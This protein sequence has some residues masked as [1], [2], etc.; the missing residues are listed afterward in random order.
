M[1]SDLEKKMFSF[2]AKITELEVRNVEL[3]E[4][5]TKLEKKQLENVIIKNLLHA[6]CVSTFGQVFQKT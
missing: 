1:E 6:S 2:M 3:K 4:G 5:L